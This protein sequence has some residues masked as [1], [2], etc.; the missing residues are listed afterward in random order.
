ML[1]LKHSCVILDSYSHGMCTVDSLFLGRGPMGQS[2]IHSR[3]T[4]GSSLFVEVRI[5]TLHSS[6]CPALKE[7]YT[8][9]SSC[10]WVVCFVSSMLR[11]KLTAR[12]D[13]EKLTQV[14]RSKLLIVE[15]RLVRAGRPSDCVKVLS[16]PCKWT[17]LPIL[18]WLI[19]LESLN[20]ILK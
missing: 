8:L 5:T 20:C 7:S 9:F 15:W 17:T 4:R 18:L 14:W 11:S 2:W 12:A 10:A 6:H 1:V 16:S 3:I 19:L 13:W